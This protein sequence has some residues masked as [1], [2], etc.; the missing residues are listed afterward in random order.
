MW[1]A[2]QVNVVL[3][4]LG[5]HAERFSRLEKRTHHPM[6]MAKSVRKTSVVTLQIILLTPY[7][8]INEQI[9]GNVNLIST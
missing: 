3:R 4:S 9:T 6:P 2:N 7:A 5:G 8:S 1:T